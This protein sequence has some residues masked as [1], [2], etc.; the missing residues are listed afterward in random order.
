MTRNLLMI[1]VLVQVYGSATAQTLETVEVLGTREQ[2]YRAT[3]AA[4]ANKS[5]T[6]AKETPFSVQVVTR[7]L[8]ADRG[9]ISF[10]EA[11]RTVPGLTPQVGFN[12]MNERFRLRG[13]AIEPQEW[14][15]SQCVHSH[16]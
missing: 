9:V 1:A 14:H 10:G 11:V 3:V 16:R 15:A 13:Y 6:P 4:T 2:G 8:I 5:D 7:E 12:G